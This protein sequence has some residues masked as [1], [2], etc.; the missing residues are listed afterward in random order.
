MDLTFQHP[1]VQKLNHIINTTVQKWNY[2]A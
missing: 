2:H 1:F